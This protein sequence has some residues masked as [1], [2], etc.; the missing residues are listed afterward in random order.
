MPFPDPVWVYQKACQRIQAWGVKGGIRGAGRG[1]KKK[2][3][4]LSILGRRPQEKQFRPLLSELKD[5]G[6]WLPAAILIHGPSGCGHKYLAA[7]LSGLLE[8]EVGKTHSPVEIT[9]GAGWQ[10]DSVETLVESVASFFT[11]ETDGQPTIA[12]IASGM[13]AELEQVPVTIIIQR[14]QRLSGGLSSFISEL[15]KDLRKELPDD[16]PNPLTV[17][18]TDESANDV[19]DQLITPATEFDAEDSDRDLPIALPRLGDF[20]CADLTKWYR[21]HGRDEDQ[22]EAEAIAILDETGGNAATILVQLA[23]GS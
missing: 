10:D 14:V 7:R 1:K 9:V 12:S 5:P 20:N 21:Q 4:D 23:S 18:V 17:I 22:A 15:W 3:V 6:A 11:D 19:G 8:K 2:A 16:T 13:A